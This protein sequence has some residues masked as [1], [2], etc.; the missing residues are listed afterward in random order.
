MHRDASYLACRVEA[1]H[2]CPPWVN[3]HT[4]IKVGGNATHSV[5]CGWLDGYGL[6]NRFD[7]EVVACEVGNIW[8]LCINRLCSQVC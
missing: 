7:A 1:W 5:V 3:H 6:G 2:R 4:P 8:Q